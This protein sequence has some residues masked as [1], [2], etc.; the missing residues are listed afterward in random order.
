MLKVIQ[1]ETVRLTWETD[2]PITLHI[3]GYDIEGKILPNARFDMVF[4]AHSTGRFP[5]TS[6][7]LE[8]S[9]ETTETHELTL[10]Y[11]EIHPK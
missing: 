8:N 10:L 6:H 11:L 2:E 7:G 4:N 5:I 3:H 1:G 9:G